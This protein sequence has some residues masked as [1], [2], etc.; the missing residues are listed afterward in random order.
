MKF[1]HIR[2]P[3]EV[4]RQFKTVTA[5]KGASMNEVISSLILQY[6]KEVKKEAA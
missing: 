3:E 4:R 6:L 2:V 1:I 5:S